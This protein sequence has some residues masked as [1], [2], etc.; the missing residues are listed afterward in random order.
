MFAG[1]YFVASKD[2][3]GFTGLRHKT[4][5]LPSTEPVVQGCMTTLHQRFTCSLLYSL[6]CEQRSSVSRYFSIRNHGFGSIFC[7][8][9]FLV[10]KDFVASTNRSFFHRATS[11]TLLLRPT[12]PVLP[13]CIREVHAVVCILC[14]A[15]NSAG[16][17][18]I[19]IYF[20]PDIFQIFLLF[21]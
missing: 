8:R 18:D 11:E 21:S 7:A 17:P 2:R 6:P 4:L 9:S 14:L 3:S 13:G 12:A 5:L 15:S 20:K 1:K 16:F 19:F 10:G